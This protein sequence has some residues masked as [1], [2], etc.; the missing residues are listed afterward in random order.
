[1]KNKKRTM[2]TRKM[3]GRNR[4]SFLYGDEPKSGLSRD[5]GDRLQSRNVPFGTS[6][7]YTFLMAAPDGLTPIL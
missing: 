2:H 3:R 1:M 4:A 5:L 6:G 7:V